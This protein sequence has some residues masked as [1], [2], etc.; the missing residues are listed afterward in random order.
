L[1]A[2]DVLVI[3]HYKHS[4]P[5]VHQ[6]RNKSDTIPN[7]TVAL[8]SSPSCPSTP[9]RCPLMRRCERKT[10]PYTLK[11][12]IESASARGINGFVRSPDLCRLSKCTKEARIEYKCHSLSRHALLE[13]I[14]LV[15]R[16]ECVGHPNPVRFPRL[17]MPASS[18][19]ASSPSTFVFSG[20]IWFIR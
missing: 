7:Y 14:N 2:L 17:S 3:L 12:N 15:C 1:P 16:N 5:H 18:T 11:R 13:N 6:S 20:W 4:L 9:R 10:S 19:P 8:S